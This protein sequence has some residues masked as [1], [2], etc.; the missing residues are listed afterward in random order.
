MKKTLINK[1]KF[2]FKTYKIDFWGYNIQKLNINSFKQ[3]KYLLFLE[4]KHPFLTKFSKRVL[5]TQNQQIYWNLR[6][7]TK[8]SIPTF[9]KFRKRNFLENFFFWQHEKRLKLF[10]NTFQTNFIRQT[11]WIKLRAKHMR[12]LFNKTKKF[13]F[14]HILQIKLSKLNLLQNP[15][16]L[17]S[18]RFSILKNRKKQKIMSLR[19][20]NL[21]YLVKYKKFLNSLKKKRKQLSYE[22]FFSTPE[23]VSTVGRKRNSW[24]WL[25]YKPHIKKNWHA[26]H[27]MQILVIHYNFFTIK[28]FK[29]WQ[30]HIFKH[31]HQHYTIFFMLENLLITFLLKLNIFTSQRHVYLLIKYGFITINKRITRNPYFFFKKNQKLSFASTSIKLQIFKLIE[32]NFFNQNKFFYMRKFFLFPFSYCIFYWPLLQIIKFKEPTVRELKNYFNFGVPT[33]LY[34]WV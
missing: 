5:L 20:K 11:Y 1:I 33:Y 31:K 2:L 25:P 27:R 18:N 16:H 24:I 19:L 17:L 30:K 7:S 32:K 4:Q 10:D 9:F 15:Y 8:K 3:W 21:K 29:N 6:S 14:K 26:L 12:Q 22:I 13:S 23:K 34:H 28:K